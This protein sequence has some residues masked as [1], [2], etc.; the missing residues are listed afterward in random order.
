MDSEQFR[1]LISA[2]EAAT[3]QEE[4]R[5]RRVLNWCRLPRWAASDLG[6][7]G[8]RCRFDSSSSDSL[9]E[10]DYESD[11]SSLSGASPELQQPSAPTQTELE[12]EATE[13]NSFVRPSD[14]GLPTNR[15]GRTIQALLNSDNVFKEPAS[16]GT[17]E[18]CWECVFEDAVRIA[19]MYLPPARPSVN[20]S[21]VDAETLVHRVETEDN[22]MPDVEIQPPKG[23]DT[24][25][26][27]QALLETSDGE[28]PQM[29]EDP[30]SEK[31][32]SACTTTGE[33]GVLPAAAVIH[34]WREQ[35]AA[36]RDAAELADLELAQ[37]EALELA[38]Q[39][40]EKRME[41][42]VVAVDEAW[43]KPAPSTLAFP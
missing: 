28:G 2:V 27:G 43:L 30:G 8:V 38:L 1:D 39:R 24:M 19:S 15:L 42:L 36:F 16:P 12:T 32:N 40:Y 11:V 18:R 41:R 22:S 3:A 7:A 34:H 21:N 25:T 31:S 29:S 6:A 35:I 26:A 33:A 10:S 37:G 9:T 17:V 5:W 13:Y 14:S 23:R 20:T 4:R